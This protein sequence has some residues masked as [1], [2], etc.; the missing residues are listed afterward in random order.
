MILVRSICVVC[1]AIL[2]A[3]A[4]AADLAPLEL[5]LDD[6]RMHDAT[7]RP[8]DGGPAIEVQST[9]RDV[10]VFLKPADRAAKLDLARRPVLEFEYFSTTGVRPF[11]VRLDPV[12]APDHLL[13][14]EDLA[15]SQAW[16]K[17]TIDL[18]PL[19]GP[20]AGRARGLRL[21]LGQRAGRTIQ[22]R[23][24]NLR[25]LNDAE[26][27]AAAD[28]AA[29]REQDRSLEQQLR[30]YLEHAY[31]AELTHIRVDAQRITIEGRAP[32][33]GA[34]L[35]LAE[36]PLHLT[37][38]QMNHLTPLLPVR[39]DADGKFSLTV[40]RRAG[41]TDRL[42]TRWALVNADG[43]LAS[44]LRYADEITPLGPEPSRPTPRN[45]KGLGALWP[46]RPLSDLDDL[47]VSFVTVNVNTNGLFRAAPAPG[48]TPFEAFGRTWYTDDAGVAHLDQALLEA[49]KRQ[50]T[51]SAI[52]LVSQA[53]AAGADPFA[54]TIAHP[55]ADPSGIYV[56]P[57]LTTADGV[58]AYAAALDF[59]ARRYSRPD[60]RF[61]RIH[62]YI[63]H[64]EVDAGWVWTNAG[65]KSL[66][67][68][69]DLYHRSMRTAHLIARQYDPHARAF[70]S[71]THHWA[72]AG[73]KHFY[74]SRDLLQ[75]LA[76]LSRAEGD[77]D[78]AIAHHPYPQDLGNPRT[79]EDKDA[80]FTF[81]TPLI[82]Y[83]NI[84]VLDAWVRQPSMMYLGKHLRTL[85]LTEQGLN[86]RD[87][88][89]VSL[90]DQAA[91]MAYAWNK[92][93]PLSTIEAFDYHNWVDNRGEG[94]L[95]IGLRRFPDDKDDPSGRKPVWDVYRALD[96]EHEAEA[97]ERYKSVVGVK[98]WDEV[99]YR[100]EVVK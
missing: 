50:I 83:R 98:G 1:F 89:D 20:A 2:A 69:L 43:A 38:D 97:T 12:P 54:R 65:E 63:L 87:Y 94:G 23:A 64:N 61:G 74:P 36:A 21:D 53:R 35:R 31:T 57:N 71:L 40:D 7:L 33:A 9:G 72:R 37:L 49:A 95:R 67:T 45:R 91:G 78:W 52:L 82:T 16:S 34:Q 70:I 84:E 13:A 96:T 8:A 6:A 59:L 80:T 81:D 55:D 30:R 90:R 73:D 76:E 11:R 68:Y 86:S 27:R 66:L 29:R 18:T 25:P 42:I 51:V 93:K 24:I 62:H 28:K 79:W 48:R 44:H 4:A 77:F 75:R 10:Y 60:G 22:L 99:R 5:Q 3:G 15:I 46:G 85:H 58:A 14:A 41:N 47:A 88:S 100:K 39:S 26:R 19:L 32:V 17:R 56:M 92:I